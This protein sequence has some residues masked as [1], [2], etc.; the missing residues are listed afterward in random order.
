MTMFQ[1]LHRSLAPSQTLKLRCECCDH[2]ATLSYDQAVAR[3]GPDATP[4]D[5]RQRA[6]CKACGTEGRVRV[7]I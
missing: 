3:C 5:I 7:W 6:K 2:H 4:M 1:N